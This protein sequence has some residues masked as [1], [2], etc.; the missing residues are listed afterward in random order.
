MRDEKE[1]LVKDDFS[2]AIHE[3]EMRK[4]A[5][6]RDLDRAIHEAEMRKDAERQ[7][8]LPKNKLKL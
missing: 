8:L 1:L 3:A 7:K 6:R 4:D 5:E 2:Q